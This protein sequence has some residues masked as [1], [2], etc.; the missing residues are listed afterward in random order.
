MR[1]SIVLMP[2]EL[3][4]GGFSWIDAG[5]PDEVERD[6]RLLGELVP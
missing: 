6:D 5:G 4:V 1:V 2:V 3:M